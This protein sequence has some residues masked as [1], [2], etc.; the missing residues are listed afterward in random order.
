MEQRINKH[1]NF[2]VYLGPQK[3]YNIKCNCDEMKI[4]KKWDIV[5]AVVL[6]LA[7]NILKY[8]ITRKI[9]SLNQDE[10]KHRSLR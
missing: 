4:D 5:I 9:S 2:E 8:F 6:K 10:S 7:S 1:F 3:I